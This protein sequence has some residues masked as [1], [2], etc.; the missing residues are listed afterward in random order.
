V[1]AALN[2]AQSGTDAMPPCIESHAREKASLIVAEQ[3]VLRCVAFLVEPRCALE[4][5]ALICAAIPGRHPAAASDAAAAVLD[6]AYSPDVW[7]RFSD[8]D[9]A[10]ACCAVS[11][12]A[13]QDGCSDDLYARAL[14]A[15]LPASLACV[16]EL[17]PLVR[18]A[19]QSAKA[20]HEFGA[21]RDASLAEA[22]AAMPMEAKSLAL[23]AALMGDVPLESVEWLVCPREQKQQEGAGGREGAAPA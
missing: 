2:A 12:A 5:C 1:I 4:L 3:L 23:R 7:C 6:S 18:A 22:S 8:I 10:C 14:C 20:Q 19:G 21:A 16:R 11:Y 17:M 13:H 9:I 15:V